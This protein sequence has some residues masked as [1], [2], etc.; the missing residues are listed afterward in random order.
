MDA[1]E[2]H[3][4]EC[5][6]QPI[7]KRARCVGRFDHYCGW[8]SNAVGLRNMRWFLAFLVVNV[9]MCTYGE[10]HD[11]RCCLGH[12]QPRVCFSP[13]ISSSCRTCGLSSLAN[14]TLVLGQKGWV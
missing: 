4:H 13:L 3:Q 10:C 6:A 11:T 9:L 2:S 5:S 14:L 8:I 12:E 7:V 1:P